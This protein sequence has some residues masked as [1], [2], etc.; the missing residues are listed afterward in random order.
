[1]PEGDEGTI[2]TLNYTRTEED[3]DGNETEVEYEVEVD[4][5]PGRP[6]PAYRERGDRN[7][8]D[9][10]DDEEFE[11][12]E[13]TRVH[14]DGSRETMGADHLYADRDLLREMAGD[15]WEPAERDEDY[16]SDR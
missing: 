3:D 16:G 9:P 2:M 11:I 1:M 7:F 10:G 12:I 6:P 15:E 8:C 13:V 14:D 4:Y 5:E